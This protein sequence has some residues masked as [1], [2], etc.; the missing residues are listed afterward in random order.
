VKLAKLHHPLRVS[1]YMLRT[2]A[3]S[4]SREVDIGVVTAF[5]RLMTLLNPCHDDLHHVC[6]NPMQCSLQ[7]A[8]CMQVTF[9]S[10]IAAC[11]QG[12]QWEKAA[13]LFEQMH[14]RGCR[15]D[16][17]TYGGLIAAYERV[18]VHVASCILPRGCLSNIL[19]RGLPQAPS[20][21][22]SHCS[23]S[24]L[25]QRCALVAMLWLD[26]VVHTGLAG[27]SSVP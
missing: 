21:A 1:C 23:L 16:P 4:V 13:E 8:W 2:K 25:L 15:P 19:R 9:N 12:A 24:E 11:A 10:L 17:V 18:S 26:A 6:S 7:A 5:E 3:L 14:G 22:L 27:C 20:C